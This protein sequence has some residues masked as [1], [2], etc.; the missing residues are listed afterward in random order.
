MHKEEAKEVG[1]MKAVK[2]DYETD[3]VYIE[4]QP[5]KAYVTFEVN[6][7]IG[8]DLGKNKVPVG[9]E[10]LEASEVLSGLFNR[11]IS[12]EAIKE[13]LCKFSEKDRDYYLSFKYRNENAVFAIPKGWKSPIV[14]AA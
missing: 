10:I 2:Y 11:R 13:V 8:V 4:I 14:D 9:V 3:S 5:K 6:D 12:K 1:K 7:R